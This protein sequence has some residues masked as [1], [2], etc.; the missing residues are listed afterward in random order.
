MGV[1]SPSAQ[2][3]ATT[4]TATMASMPVEPIAAASPQTSSV[5]TAAIANTTGTNQATTRSAN[6]WISVFDSCAWRTSSTTCASAVC[7]AGLSTR[8]VSEPWPLIVPARISLPGCLSTGNRL[9]GQP[10]LVD[11]GIA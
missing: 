6:R 1:A 11:T 5:T 3:Q 2:G 8:A 10:R 9:A 4:S 7:P